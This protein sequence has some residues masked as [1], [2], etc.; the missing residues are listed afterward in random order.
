LPGPVGQAISGSV[1]LLWEAYL[2]QLLRTYS[3]QE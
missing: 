2:E 3:K 1:H